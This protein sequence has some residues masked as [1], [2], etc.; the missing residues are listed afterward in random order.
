M[1]ENTTSLRADRNRRKA[2]AIL[3]GGV[4]L[5]IGAIMTLAAWNDSVWAEGEFATEAWNVQGSVDGGTTW[6]EYASSGDAGQLQ[7]TLGNLSMV[8]GDTVYA[9]FALRVGP[10]TSNLDASVVLNRAQVQFAGAFTND[11]RLTVT[12]ASY[13]DCTN[14]SPGTAITGWPNNSGLT[15]GGSTPITVSGNGTASNLCFV[16][17]L[18]ANSGPYTGG[19]QQTGSVQWK[20][21]AESV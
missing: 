14:G 13:A 16:V 10:D 5:G 15:A 6:A 8:P 18:P 2:R 19:T 21:D 4:V 1:S 12:N 7:F 3:A 9:P 20:F 17:H 11:L